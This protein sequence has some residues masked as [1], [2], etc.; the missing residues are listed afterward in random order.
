MFTFVQEI[1]HV[2]FVGAVE[3]LAA[4][5]GHP[6]DVH[7][8][9]QSQGTVATQAARRGDGLP[10]SSGTTS[11]CSSDPAAR[12]GAR[13]PAQPRAR[14]R[15]RPAV[16][17]RLGARRLGRAGRGAR[18]SSREL[19]RDD[20]AGVHE[21]CRPDAGRVPGPRAVPDLL[22]E[23]RRGGVRRPGPA[24]LDRSGEVQELAGDADLRQ[25]EDAVRPELGQGR[26]RRRRSGR[27]VR[28]LH[29][30][31]RLP[32]GRGGA[33]R[34]HVRHG[35]RP[36]STSGC[37]SATPASV[38]LAFD[39]DAAGQ[40]AAERFYEWEQKYQVQVSV[41][42]FPEGKDPGELAQSRP[43]GAGRGG[44]R[45]RCRS[46]ASGCSACMG[47]RPARTPEERVRLAEQAMAVVN[48]HPERERAQAVRRRGGRP[49]RAAGQRSGGDRRAAPAQPGGAR[50]RHASRGATENA[51][52]VA[53]AL[54]LQDWDV[55]RRRG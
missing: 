2:D 8:A 30:R 32:S 39:A 42:R 15:R 6:A 49:D 16:P 41:A 19:L 53:I 4:K 44:R 24:R 26:H 23:R 33:G 21:Q 45:R 1:E 55:D 17:A 48:E 10:P 5:V 51:E 3:H 29:R 7:D 12:A 11:G 52:F 36:R 37:S 27:R 54:L 50:S 9:G 25:V 43:G 20:R 18:G 35:A 47:A 14:G 22:R 28:G 46:S 40:G 31:D 34:R 38:V 13:L